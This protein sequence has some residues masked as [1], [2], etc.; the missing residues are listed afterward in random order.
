MRS[1]SRSR[2]PLHRHQPHAGR[3]ELDGEGQPVELGHQLGQ[4]RRLVVGQ[5]ARRAGAEQLHRLRHGEGPHR[6]AALAGEPQGHPA[7]RQERQ[8]RG[9]LQPRGEHRGRRGGH[10][11]EVVEHH[12]GAP[13]GVQRVAELRHRVGAV[14][15]HLERPRRGVQD[16]LEVGR[17]GEVDEPRPA[18]Q[19]RCARHL[20]RQPRLAGPPGPE[21]GD[22]PRRRAH[23]AQHGRPLGLAPDERVG[24]PREP[25]GPQGRRRRGR[26]A[27]LGGRVA[28]PQLGPDPGQ[29]LQ[30][31]RAGGLAR[32]DALQRVGQRRRRGEPALRLRVEA[33]PEH[34]H[35]PGR[36]GVELAPRVGG[37]H[38][39]LQRAAVRGRG[40][41][42]LEQ[43][44]PRGQA[45]QGGPQ[46]EQV[47][48]PV[49][50][51]LALLGGHVRR[52]APHAAA[53]GRQPRDAQIGQLDQARLV[54]QQ[55]RR[56]D[57]AVE[58]R[59]RAALE[60]QAVDVA[61]RR[62]RLQAH[63]DQ[64]PAPER[65]VARQLAQRGAGDQL[66]RDPRAPVGLADVVG[67]D[68]VR[69]RQER[70]Q[71]GLAEQHLA[72]VRRRRQELERHLAAEPLEPVQERLPHLAHA[73]APEHADELVPTEPQPGGQVHG[74]PCSTTPHPKAPAPTPIAASPPTHPG[75]R[76]RPGRRSVTTQAA[77]PPATRSAPAA[78]SGVFSQGRRRAIT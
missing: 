58:Q 25:A 52:R 53:L 39:L 8:R 65:P 51:A 7:R 47:G 29:A 40:G 57:V 44:A 34:L 13:P 10:L 35:Q 2:I 3:R 66:H 26:A 33:A 15:A 18:G 14:E 54:H 68:H 43:R 76:P 19:L 48:P 46:A 11:L 12:D 74:R 60:R 6:H 9:G 49:A 32:A 64:R 17:L 75:P 77:A 67:R 73:A 28:G 55:V 69:V 38:Q 62:R 71:A 36:G 16:A 24:R 5:P 21:Q 4:Q 1:I 20:E 42:G 22:Q 27:A 37:G 45:Q 78:S 63:V 56:L 41:P 59:Q 72:L 31:G 23:L 50:V 61:Q 70:A 30:Q